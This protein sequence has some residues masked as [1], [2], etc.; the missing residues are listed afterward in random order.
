M[1]CWAGFA[2]SIEGWRSCLLMSELGL[3]LK[4]FIK[5]CD[6]KFL[7]EETKTIWEFLIYDHTFIKSI[8][9]FKPKIQIKS[10]PKPKF[11]QFN[12]FL[13]YH[14]YKVS[15][16]SH[17]VRFKVMI[18]IF[19]WLNTYCGSQDFSNCDHAY[20]LISNMVFTISELY[21]YPLFSKYRY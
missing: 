8:N 3:W 21:L 6:W 17:L 18:C 5:D 16:N 10:D 2:I 14:M 20:H 9:K 1:R 7:I 13:S 4:I 15:F 19:F 12:G 11:A